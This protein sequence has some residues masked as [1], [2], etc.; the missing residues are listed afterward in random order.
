M[1]TRSVA[2]I[3][4]RELRRVSRPFQGWEQI[5]TFFNHWWASLVRRI[6]LPRIALSVMLQQVSAVIG[7]F[8]QLRSRLFVAVNHCAITGRC[9]FGH[10]MTEQ[11]GLVQQLLVARLDGVLMS[12][13]VEAI[14]E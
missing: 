3:D 9:E 8:F 5:A 12:G 13:I 10:E 11:E 1:K 14:E 6:S 4:R 2:R 7:V